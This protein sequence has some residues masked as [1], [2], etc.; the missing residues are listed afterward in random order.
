MAAFTGTK[1]Q[2]CL[3]QFGGSALT[4]KPNKRLLK[5]MLKPNA[6]MARHLAFNSF[7]WI[8][9][10]SDIYPADPRD[11]CF[12]GALLFRLTYGQQSGKAYMRSFKDC[13]MIVSK[14]IGQMDPKNNLSGLLGSR[15]DRFLKEAFKAILEHNCKLHLEVTDVSN[16]SVIGIRRVQGPLEPNSECYLFSVVGQQFIIPPIGYE[17]IENADSIMRFIEGLTAEKFQMV[18]KFRAKETF[19]ITGSDGEI[20]SGSKN[21]VSSY[22]M[23]VFETTFPLSWRVADIDNYVHRR[24]KYKRTFHLLD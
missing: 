20:L 5:T 4:I 24:S 6:C 18:I 16:L 11:H 3:S 10:S 15:L 17:T 19:Y 22:H 14:L 2:R 23:W 12:F 21:S 9:S 1:L 8:Q 7:P 13:V